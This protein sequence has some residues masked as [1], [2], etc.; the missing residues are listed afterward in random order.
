MEPDSPRRP[1]HVA[2]IVESGVTL[3]MD[4]DYF[5]EF[6]SGLLGKPQSLERAYSGQFSITFDEIVNTYQL[7]EQRIHQQN[8]ATLVQFTVSIE[9]DDNSSVR[10]NSFEQFVHYS[11]VKPLVCIGLTLSWVYLVKFQQKNVPEK[12]Q[13]DLSFGADTGFR[14]ALNITSIS[15]VAFR[16]G[17]GGVHLRISHTERTWGNDIGS[18]LDG[19]IKKLIQIPGGLRTWIWLHSER[20]GAAVGT[21]LLVGSLLGAGVTTS[22]FI[23]SNKTFFSHLPINKD[24]SIIALNQKIDYMIDASLT[25]SWPIFTVM[26]LG[27]VFFSILTSIFLGVWVEK[28]ADKQPPSFILLSQESIREKKKYESRMNRDWYMFWF[29]VAASICAGVISNFVFNKF[30]ASI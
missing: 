12:Q 25:G 6:I 3:P 20:V 9:Y 29:S 27:F 28:N 7:L 11:E 5:A 1:S 2:E 10:I 17:G 24:T 22:S 30:F 16:T 13:I 23:N 15:I 21:T 14:R 18:L 4:S 19:H 8:E 26:L